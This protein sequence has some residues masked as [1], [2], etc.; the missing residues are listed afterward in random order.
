MQVRQ[1]RLPVARRA[2]TFAV[3]SVERVVFTVPDI[4]PAE[5]FYTAFGLDVKRAGPRIDLYTH[6]HSHCWMTVVA[7]GQP[8][9]LQ[10]VSLGIF[11]EDRPAFEA[12]I[13]ALGIG[14]GPHPMAM[15]DSGLWLRSPDGM[16]MQ[17]LVCDKVS[18][19]CK[20]PAHPVRIPARQ[21][22]AAHAR[23]QCARVFPRWLSHVLLFTPDVARMLGFCDEVLGLRLSDRSGDLVAFMHS[24]H[25]SDHHLLA[26]VKS[27]GPGLHHTS[28]D[29]GSLDEVGEGSE[30][31]RTAG[32]TEGWGVG[33]HVLGSNYFYYARDPWG[34]FAEYSFD[35]DFVS[36]TT[37]WTAGDYAPEDSFYLWGPVVPEWFVANTE[38]PAPSAVEASQAG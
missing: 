22:A 38:L 36:Q 21:T 26:F 16:P 20:T 24:P 12:K 19:S 28:W 18:P 34:S 32:F 11:A 8:K 10:Y 23:S 1:D 5:A 15:D 37:D 6:G 14:C 4:A 2:G 17:L 13:Q 30:Q 35:I 9:A 29:V 33:R 27:G 25:G 31:M 3:H 7:N